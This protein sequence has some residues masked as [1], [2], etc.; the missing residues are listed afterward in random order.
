MNGNPYDA[1]AQ[2]FV[3]CRIHSTSRCVKPPTGATESI[4]CAPPP[5]AG[6]TEVWRVMVLLG[7]EFMVAALSPSAIGSSEAR[8]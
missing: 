6:G 1:S 8:V 4:V 3:F 5:L 2:G 7:I